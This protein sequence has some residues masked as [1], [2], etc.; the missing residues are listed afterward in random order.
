M[1]DLIGSL[2]QGALGSRGKKTRGAA[3]FLSG[4]S[5]SFINA[6]TVLTAAGLAWGAFEA[7][8]R[9]QTDASPA[10]PSSP[11]TPPGGVPPPLVT[12]SSVATPPPL[13]GGS[14]VAA[15]PPLPGAPPVSGTAESSR[16][17][18]PEV[19]RWVRLMISAAR[20]DG[21][22]SPEEQQAILARARD[23]GA[24]ELVAVELAVSRPLDQIVAGVDDAQAK[25]DMYVLAYTIVRADE[26]VSGA[27]RIYLA[28]LAHG[29]GLD[30]GTVSRLEAET[31]ARIDQER[32]TD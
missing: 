5:G 28:Q 21:V 12:G 1:T 32:S 26:T 11:S 27:E 25:A 13:P 19:L 4:R 29:L 3:R 23:A 9:K 10:P 7:A 14:P 15:P 2:L 20:A 30:A 18:P 16:T 24:E 6:S 22:L 31:G 17:V 8:T